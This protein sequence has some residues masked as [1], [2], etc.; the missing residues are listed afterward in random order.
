MDAHSIGKMAIFDPLSQM[1]KVISFPKN[2]IVEGNLLDNLQNRLSLVDRSV[3]LWD[4]EWTQKKITRALKDGL[5]VA[6]GDDDSTRGQAHPG[7]NGGSG[8]D[9]KRAGE[10][11]VRAVNTYPNAK[12]QGQ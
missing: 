3:V 11:H 2:D 1:G 5:N 9:G 4:R 12:Q 8:G 7:D 10:K 6:Y